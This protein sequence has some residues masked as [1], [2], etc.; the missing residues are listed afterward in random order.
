MNAPSD[1]VSN[2]LGDM[3]ER[4]LE[5]LRSG[6]HSDML[7]AFLTSSI[8]L[9]LSKLVDPTLDLSAFA[10][11]AVSVLTQFAPIDQVALGVTTDDLPAVH[12]STG[13]ADGP[14]GIS[15]PDDSRY[16]IV[17]PEG[18]EGYL[19]VR[20]VPAPLQ[21]AGLIEQAA[22]HLAGGMGQMV[23]SERLRRQAAAGRAF[24]TLSTIDEQWGVPQLRDFCEALAAMPGANAAGITVEAGRLGGAIHVT[25]G[26]DGHRDIEREALAD[27]R[28]PVKVWVRLHSDHSIEQ[29]G[30][31]LGLIDSFLATIDRA[32][33]GVRLRGEAET[34]PLTGIGNRRMG[35]RALVAA[36][37]LAERQGTSIAVLMLDLDHFKKVNDDYGHHVGDAVLVAFAE[38]LSASVRSFDTVARWGGEEFLVVCPACD[39]AGAVALANRLL[40]AAP[41]ACAAVL[42]DGARQTA[43]I[44]IALYPI[45]SEN[46]DALLRAA[47]QALYRAKRRSRNV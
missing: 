39:Q 30:K 35:S 5:Q 18:G 26:P 25:V 15:H 14:D 40:A 11:A 37:N 29:D 3:Q 24:E 7:V 22:R 8:M 10:E 41:E 9:E 4:A 21:R 43:S 20:N 42:P 32:E 46:P 1:P 45:T 13:M 16:P 17:L 12:A 47:D 36:R 38:M 44:G 2:L 28:T 19:T 33:Q 31:I 6:E 27:A 23:E 34:D